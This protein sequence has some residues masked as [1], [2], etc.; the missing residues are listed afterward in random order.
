[1][2]KLS[3]L[4]NG[5]DVTF[6]THQAGDG[7]E[8]NWKAVHLEKK[9]HNRKGKIR[10]PLS[11]NMAPSWSSGISRD[12][13]EKITREVRDELGDNQALV[14]ELAE[15]VVDILSRYSSGR[16]TTDDA[17]IAA[18][19]LAGYFGLNEQFERVV[20]RYAHGRLVLF[21]SVHMNS[22]TRLLQEISQSSDR[23]VVRKARKYVPIS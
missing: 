11:G 13:F 18:K 9:M 22:E 14:E 8:V 7:Q 4:I 17:K 5:Q 12:N 19:R 1:M 23:V 16:A 21:T 10:F 3:R 6:D 20:E 2:T 15:T